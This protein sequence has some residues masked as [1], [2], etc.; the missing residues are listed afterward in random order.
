MQMFYGI[1]GEYVFKIAFIYGSF[2]VPDNL[3]VFGIPAYPFLIDVF[4]TPERAGM[5]QTKYQM[6]P[7]PFKFLP[8]GGNLTRFSLQFFLHIIRKPIFP[9]INSMRN[10]R[11]TFP[12]FSQI[13]ALHGPDA[14][15]VI[16][17]VDKP[18]VPM[19]NGTPE[20][21]PEIPLLRRHIL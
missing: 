8:C 5:A 9:K 4:S 20:L 18:M 14:V 17:T 2:L 21:V 12:A 19:V 13:K 3:S 11:V 7:G 10:S 6:M 16:N 15:T 1:M